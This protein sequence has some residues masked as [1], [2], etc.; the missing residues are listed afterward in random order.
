T[1][2]AFADTSTMFASP[3]ALMC[4]NWVI[5]FPSLLGKVIQI[6]VA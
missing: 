6:G 5:V 4:V 3:D 2:S 1:V